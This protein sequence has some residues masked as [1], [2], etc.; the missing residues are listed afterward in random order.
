MENRTTVR[1]SR[2]RGVVGVERETDQTRVVPS[3]Q[4]LPVRRV[5]RDHTDFQYES[6]I[7]VAGVDYPGRERRFEVVYHRLSVRYAKRLRVKVRVDER[8][9]VPSIVSVYSVANWIEREVWDRLG[10]GFEGHP[11]RR[12]IL[13][14]Y[15]FEGHPRRKDFPL[16]GYTEVRYDEE[17]KR[18]VSEPVEVSQALRSV[19][20]RGGWNPRPETGRVGGR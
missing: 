10:V 13:T 8:G 5:R 18:V 17:A 7:D 6:L 16:T 20:Y 1:T 11:D 12:R 14:D 3:G 2:K 15:G 4:L 19:S 9:R